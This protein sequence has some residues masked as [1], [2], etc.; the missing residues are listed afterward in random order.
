MAD[1]VERDI[2]QPL[3]GAPGSIDRELATTLRRLLRPA[4]EWKEISRVPR[5]RLLRGERTREVV[6]SHA[7]E[8]VFLAAC[9]PPLADVAVLL[10]DTGLRLGEAASLER[11]PGKA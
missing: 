11:P 8:R 2:D 3:M 9:P 6:L 7:Q 5:V 1:V 10:L 4:H